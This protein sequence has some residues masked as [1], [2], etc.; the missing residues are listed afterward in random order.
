MHITLAH[1]NLL[2]YIASIK[3]IIHPYRHNKL[4][5]KKEQTNLPY[6]VNFS[7]TSRLTPVLEKP[8][9]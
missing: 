4:P 9:S 2:N 5:L 8:P 3:M 6:F 1:T 7:I